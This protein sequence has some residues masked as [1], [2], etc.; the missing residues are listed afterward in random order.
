VLIDSKSSINERVRREVPTLG[1]SADYALNDQQSIGGS[2]KWADR[3]GLR[4]Y[5]QLNASSTPTGVETNS[6]QRL[7]AGHDP[8]TDYDEKL[9][10]TQKLR[11][12]GET[13]EFSLHRSTSRQLEH[14][15]YTNDSF[16]PRRRPSTTTSPSTK[17]T[18]PPNLTPTM[19]CRFRGRAL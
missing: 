12:P 10:F 11:Q 3:G 1:L 9:R 16:V 7:S 6:S 8:E 4:T 13:L 14:Y 18:R 17:I 5:T 2:V 19:R 15:D